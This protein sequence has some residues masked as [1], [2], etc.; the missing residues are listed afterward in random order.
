MPIRDHSRE[1]A[2][3]LFFELLG[4]PFLQKNKKAMTFIIA[5]D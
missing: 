2:A 3:N 1:F 5:F 4:P